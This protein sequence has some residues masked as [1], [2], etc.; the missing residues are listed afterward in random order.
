[1][2]GRSGWSVLESVIALSLS[3]VVVHMGVSAL[4]AARSAEAA[5]RAESERL[6]AVRLVRTVVGQDLAVGHRGSDWTSFPPDSLQLKAFRGTALPCTSLLSGSSPDSVYQVSWRGLR[7]PNSRKDSLDVLLADG[8]WSSADLR[9]DRTTNVRCPADTTL[10]LRRWVVSPAIPADNPPIL[11]RYWERGSYH[12]VDTVL[13]YRS[14]PRKTATSRGS[15]QPLLPPVIAAPPQPVRGLGGH[16]HHPP[17]FTRHRRV[18][19]AHSPRGWKPVSRR[20]ATGW[21]DT[22]MALVTTIVIAL[23]LTALAHGLIRLAQFEYRASRASVSQMQARLAA[24]DGVL[25]LLEQRPDSGRSKAPT[26]HFGDSLAGMTGGATY[27]AWLRRLS[28]EVWLAEGVAIKSGVSSPTVAISTWALDPAYQVSRVRGALEAGA[29]S[30]SAD[31]VFIARFLDQKNAPLSGCGW[32]ARTDSLRSTPLVP[33]WPAASPISFGFFSMDSLSVRLAN[34]GT[35]VQGDLDR[36]GQPGSEGMLVVDGNVTLSSSDH[37]GF[38]VARGDVTLAGSTIVTGLVRAG[39]TVRLLGA[40]SVVA[41]ACWA[42]H[43]LGESPLT[44]PLPF[45]GRVS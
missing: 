44:S 23:A 36:S 10:T 20:Y 45:P 22:G 12:L 4:M 37:S 9:A 5:T 34:T 11:F 25:R 2:R 40:S 29:V 19:A 13:S 16:S 3:M 31:S 28:A 17:S 33:N 27:T 39:G 26:W 18:V 14:R 15:R 41:S 21:S 32:G 38:L 42:T 1:M 8:S 30:P 6:A 35:Y 24:T 43:A 7:R